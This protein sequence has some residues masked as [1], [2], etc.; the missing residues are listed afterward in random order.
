MN[1]LE[2]DP[3]T[4]A[5]QGNA[6]LGI[7]DSGKSYTAVG[8]A[9]RLFDA[10]I[11][12]V[13]FDPI[14][15]WRFLRVPAPNGKGY[16]AVV[17]GGAAGD[18]PLTVESAPAIV[19]AAMESGVSL[20]IDLYDM[21]ISKADWRRIVADSVRVL[22]YENG[23]HGLRHI[24]IE[25]AAEFCPQ[26][27]SP[28]QGKVYA[29][30]E[31]LARMGGNARLGYTLI[32]QRAEEVSKAVLE[33]CDNLLLHRQKGKNSLVSL[34]KWLDVGDVK[35]GKEIVGTL[36]T[37]PQG[38][39]WAWMAGTERP[40]HVKVPQKNSFEPDRRAMG[41][42]DGVIAATTV[43][44]AQFVHD[45]RM[46]ISSASNEGAKMDTPKKL[47]RGSLPT[48]IQPGPVATITAEHLA[49]AEQRGY[50]AGLIE[51]EKRGRRQGFA[52]ALNAAQQAMNGLRVPETFECE[53]PSSEKSSP[54]PV[55]QRR[56]RATTGKPPGSSAS[57]VAGSNPA[58]GNQLDG[59]AVKLLEAFKRYPVGGLTWEEACIV[60]GMIPGN[61]YFYKGKKQLLD[62]MYVFEHEGQ[63]II[64]DPAE[65]RTRPLTRTEIMATW[66]KL[67]QPAPRMLEYLLS[68]STPPASI[69]VLAAAIGAKPGNGYWYGGIKALRNANLIED[70]KGVVALSKFVQE[71]E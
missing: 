19:R 18:L 39:C 21:E 37:L 4:F 22:L 69:D 31:K 58:G 61:G 26:R 43:D 44:V 14:G 70:G 57:E 20:V 42:Q 25:E 36:P 12:F 53:R 9:E 60:A 28:E 8:I 50:D 27:P 2:I 17:A 16:P 64:Q 5:S 63:V 7:R 48:D 52:L 71:A 45:L 10:G 13:A 23:R 6:I 51:G 56:E 66:S 1:Q 65:G 29:E 46:S 35:A 34:G 67:K 59:A 33:L 11:P 40:V 15:R 54:A 30:I 49:A 41:R 32:N 24:F 38:E 68:K 47:S 62:G 3:Q 55:A